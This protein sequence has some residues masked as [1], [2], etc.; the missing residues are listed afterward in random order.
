MSSGN[1]PVHEI[2]LGRVRASIWTNE[3]DLQ[4]VWFN[5][6]ISRVYRD[7][8]EWKTTTSFGRDDLP[9]V[10]KAADMA[11]AWIWNNKG[12]DGGGS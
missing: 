9:I 6:S 1:R 7:G 8:D 4:S 10:A 3:G 5:V 11:Y 12:G 2:K